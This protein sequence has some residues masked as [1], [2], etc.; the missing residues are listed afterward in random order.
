MGWAKLKSRADSGI[1]DYAPG[2]PYA[3]DR[4]IVLYAV[5]HEQGSANNTRYAVAYNTNGGTGSI[6]GHDQVYGTTINLRSSKPTWAGHTFAGWATSK[7]RADAGVVDYKSG[8]AYSANKAVILY[9]VW[10]AG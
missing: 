2:S 5:W 6:S 4:S 3:A 8:S 9:A 10:K 1:V 7:T